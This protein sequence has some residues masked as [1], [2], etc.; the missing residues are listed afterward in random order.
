MNQRDALTVN[1]VVEDDL[2]KWGV[3]NAD[4]MFEFF[5]IDVRMGACLKTSLLK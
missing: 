5:L 1:L 4:S 2:V 3:V